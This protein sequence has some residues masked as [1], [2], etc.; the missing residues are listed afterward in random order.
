[1]FFLVFKHPL[2]EETGMFLHKSAVP[3]KQNG[4][5]DVYDCDDLYDECLLSY[6]QQCWYKLTVAP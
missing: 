1:M 6:I 3:G 5:T 2:H 4:Y